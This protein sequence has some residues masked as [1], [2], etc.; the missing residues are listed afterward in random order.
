MATLT[1]QKKS[2]RG[3]PTPQQGHFC[4][5]HLAELDAICVIDRVPVHMCVS[6]DYFVHNLGMALTQFLEQWFARW[7]GWVG[8][9]LLLVTFDLHHAPL[10]ITQ[11]LV[12]EVEDPVGNV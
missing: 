12:N 8:M 7:Y 4:P 1:H 5:E 6:S 3:K 10:T 11:T 2:T 9:S